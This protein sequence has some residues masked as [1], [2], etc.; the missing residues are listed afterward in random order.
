[1]VQ[2]C[3]QNDS[4]SHRWETHLLIIKNTLLKNIHNEMTFLIHF[5]RYLVGKVVL[6]CIFKIHHHNATQKYPIVQFRDQMVLAL[7]GAHLDAALNISFQHAENAF[8][9]L[10]G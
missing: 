9:P 8:V 1:M 4:K 3:T 10:K 5:I 6:Q 2:A 7:R